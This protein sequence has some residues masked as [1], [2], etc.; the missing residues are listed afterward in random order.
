MISNRINNIKNK[1][2]DISSRN[3]ILEKDIKTFT[4]SIKD[5]KLYLMRI[6]EAQVLIMKFCQDSVENFKNTIAEMSAIGLSDVFDETFKLLIEF[7][8]RG[9]QNITSEASITLEHESGLKVDPA[10]AEGGGL[11][12]CLAFLLRISL[13]T[14]NIPSVRPILILDEPLR[15]LS[16]D[17][18]DLGGIMINNICKELNIQ[19]IMSSNESDIAKAGDN[20]INVSDL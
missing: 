17:K 13:L 9:K 10:Y 14:M 16:E 1:I 15:D 3:K 19:I 4:N 5:K 18:R 2:N 8:T 7:S 12:D 11:K 20:I 6:E